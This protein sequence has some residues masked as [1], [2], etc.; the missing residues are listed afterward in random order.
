MSQVIQ[1]S[2]RSQALALRC[3]LCGVEAAASCNCGA[4]YEPASVAVARAIKN[5]PAKS[6]RAIAEIAGV[7]H[8]T[9]NQIRAAGG[10]H[11]PP[12]KVEGRDGKSYSSPARK[13]K[14]EVEVIVLEPLDYTF[15]MFTTH[16][17]PW[18]EQ[19]DGVG[20]IAFLKL[21]RKEVGYDF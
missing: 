20:K 14:P 11:F 6:N 15:H 3:T 2:K 4:V 18:F 17:L 8:T 13:P 9:V 21:V 5:N 19:L 12:E 16:V 1:L 7:T 10:N